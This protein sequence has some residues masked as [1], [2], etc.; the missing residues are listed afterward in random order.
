MLAKHDIGRG[1][2]F[3]QTVV[4]HGL[5]ALRGFL[6]RLKNGHQG[7]LPGIARLR[8]QCRRTDQPGDMHVVAAHMSH[9][10][11]V[12]FGIRRCDLAG[13]GK[14]GVLG[15]RQRIHVRAQHHR[16]PLAVAE[17]SDHARLADPVVTS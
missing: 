5:G 8:Q 7:A 14:A 2:A 4:D 9:R 11:G 17:Q 15:D 10:H 16:R 1:E 13:I 6:A 12:P 3:E